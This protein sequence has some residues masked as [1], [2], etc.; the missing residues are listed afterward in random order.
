[1]E[2]VRMP[3]P[4]LVRVPVVVP[5]T[6]LMTVLPAPPTVRPRPA[7]LILPETVSVP[8]SELMRL[9]VTRATVP[10]QVLAPEMLRSAPS[11]EMPVPFK[12][13]V[14]PVTVMLF[15]ICS[16]APAVTDAPP[17]L[18]PSAELFWILSTP[19]ETVVAPV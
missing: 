3:A 1:M 18:V 5:M 19:A 9:A 7:P 14:S 2:R 15:C 17:A 6:P 13:R 11:L 12:V 10:V 4:S 16:A 8:A